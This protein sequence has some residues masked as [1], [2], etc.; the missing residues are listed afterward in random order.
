MGLIVALTFDHDAISW[1]VSRKADPVQM[2]RGEYGPRVGL[3][4]VLDVLQRHDIRST[5]FV[6]VHT[7][8]TFPE[9][10]RAM[11]DGG[12]E[13]AGHGWAHENFSRL[14]PAKERDL[15]V[16]TRDALAQ[17]WG[18]EVRGFRAPFWALSDR[19]LEI[20]EECGFTYDSSLM[21]DDVRFYLVR[22]GDRHRT[23]PKSVLGR[24]GKLVEVPISRTLDDWPY[25]EASQSGN[26]PMVAP[27]HVLEIW[28]AEL[29][30]LHEN[31]PGGVFTLTMH[32]ESIGRPSR[33]AMLD[34]FIQTARGL[35]GVEFRRVDEAVDAWLGAG[36]KDRANQ[37][38]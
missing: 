2:S 24:P 36:A 13:L 29:R 27:S 21:A 32:P 15:L 35:S 18:H 28:T 11:I 34:T 1:E 4:R 9:G 23:E 17:L 20:V 33:I 12:H 6:P 3:W 8:L 10:I 7:A 16:R 31:E 19:T 37:G 30:W 5:F 14:T 38:D 26:A 22:H 25:F